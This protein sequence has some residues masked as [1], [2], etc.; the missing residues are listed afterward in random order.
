M[1]VFAACE[2]IALPV[3]GN[4]AVLNLRRSFADRDGI[5]DLTAGLSAQPASAVN[6]V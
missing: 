4:S 1:T 2:Q 6:D 5:N 3:T